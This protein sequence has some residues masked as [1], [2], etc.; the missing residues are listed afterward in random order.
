ME[1]LKKPTNYWTR[2]RVEV[3]AQFDSVKEFR[4]DGY[5]GACGCLQSWMVV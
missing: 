2:E 5:R 4:K 1:E 3:Y